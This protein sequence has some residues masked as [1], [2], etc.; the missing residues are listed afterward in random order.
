MIALVPAIILPLRNAD[1]A[2]VAPS[3][4]YRSVADSEAGVSILSEIVV[5]FDRPVS[6]VNQGTFVLRDWRGRIV[7]ARIAYDEA[8]NQAT[9]VP[10]RAMRASRS[11]QVALSKGIRDGNDTS[12]GWVS[13][14]FSTGAQPS[15]GSRFAHA[16][17][18]R[19]APGTVTGIQVDGSGSVITSRTATLP[20]HSWATATARATING[21]RYLLIANGIW[22]GLFVPARSIVASRVSRQ[23]P[24]ASDGGDGGDGG[25]EA[26]QPV[27]F[28]QP[29]TPSASAGPSPSDEVVGDA[30][31]PPTG[32]SAPT[33]SAAPTAPTVAPAPSPR[34]DPGVT[35]GRGIVISQAEIRSLPT[36]GAAWDS[37][38]RT[39]DAAAGSPNLADNS[40]DNNVKVLAKALVYARTG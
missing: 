9:L 35:S 30:N 21:D 40:Q 29:S 25:P 27:D 34:V 8:S 26:P 5:R 12:L 32:S 1:A 2:A 38:K 13:W 37:L 20:R 15:A 6:G 33:P 3:I 17:D 39:A 36:S 16:R 18:V 28:E 31:T 10:K 4:Q 19:F 14:K 22:E 23:A 24:D 11:Y 7:P